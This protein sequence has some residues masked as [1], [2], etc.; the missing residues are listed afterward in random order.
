M[1]ALSIPIRQEAPIW[2]CAE[3]MNA[4]PN[5]ADSPS[6][7]KSNPTPMHRWSKVASRPKTEDGNQ[8]REREVH[9]GRN[10]RPIRFSIGY[11]DQSSLRA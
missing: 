1:G 10:Q 4:I 11:A 8:S 5:H 7:H 3:T 2:A 6:A 9:D